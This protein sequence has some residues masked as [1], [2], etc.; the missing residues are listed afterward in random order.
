MVKTIREEIKIQNIIKSF[1]EMVMKNK[2]VLAAILFGS[3][4]RKEV[5]RYVDVC[6]VMFPEKVSGGFDKRVEYSIA[7]KL[8]VQVFQDL[9]IYIRKRILKEGKV[10]HCKDKDTLYDIAI[11]TIKEFELF[12]PKYELYIEGVAHG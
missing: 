4:A 8:D 1:E 9:P 10:I 3:Y 11:E 12:R 5:A 7:E 6:I 2:D